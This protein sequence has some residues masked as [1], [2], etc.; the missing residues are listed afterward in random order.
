LELL[1]PFDGTGPL[2]KIIIEI[3]KDIKPWGIVA[4]ILLLGFSNAFA[5]SMPASEEYNFSTT[6]V[7]G[8]F[9]GILTTYLSMLGTSDL[10]QYTRPEAVLMFLFFMFLMVVVMMNLLIA[11]MSDSHERVSLS[12]QPS[13]DCASLFIVPVHV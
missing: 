13:H 8:P 3:L 7:G 4:L 11:I 1:K 5:V 9:S 6:G 2:I 12:R 10:E